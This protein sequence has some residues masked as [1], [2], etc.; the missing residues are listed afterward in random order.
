LPDLSQSLLLISLM[1]LPFLL[2]IT[3]HE[4][5]HAFAAHLLGDASQRASRRLSFNP[6]VHLDPVGS[7]AIPLVAIFTGFPFLIGYAKPVMIQPRWFK[8]MRRDMILVALAGPAGNFVVAIFCAYIWRFSYGF[9][10]ANG[11]WIVETM[12]YGVFL[13]CLF[14]V[15]NLLPIPPLD[16]GGVV[17]QLLPYEMAQ[18]YRSVAPF[19]FIL[20][21][22]I[23]VFAKPVI[24]V[25]TFF[26]SSLVID[27]VG[28]PL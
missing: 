13:N 5:G 26:M 14:M 16:G 25:P 18:K 24:L 3:L 12:K 1:A 8:N 23:V 27:L 15:F 28:V 17:E 20:L 22:V 9:G 10:A 19:G 4:A 21:M 2:A 6:L 7:V 11:E